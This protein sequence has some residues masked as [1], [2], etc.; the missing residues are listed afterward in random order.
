MIIL[1]I[2]LFIILIILEKY[3]NTKNIE[4]FQI[5][6][7]NKGQLKRYK[8]MF[9]HIPKTGGLGLRKYWKCCGRRHPTALELKNKN[10]MKF[11]K[12]FK[13]CFV[14]NPWDRMVS[15]YFYLKSGGYRAKVVSK[16]SQ[17]KKSYRSK[18][19]DI[20][21]KIV[22]YVNSVSFDD[23]VYN[24]TEFFPGGSFYIK[25]RW[26]KYPVWVQPQYLWVCDQNDN[27]IVDKILKFEDYKD[28]VE[29][30]NN[31][32]DIETKSNKKVNS[33][34]HSNYREYYNIDTLDYVSSIYKKDIELFDYSF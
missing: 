29:L 27:I 10:P 6:K 16:K 15:C 24:I 12:S 25:Q 11:Y 31:L 26:L 3:E 30:L 19:G 18:Y 2:L 7:F 33:S 20:N 1:I 4:D 9:I 14:R 8:K 23:F 13:F 5:K 22:D 17:N 21:R 32:F 34:K 28:N